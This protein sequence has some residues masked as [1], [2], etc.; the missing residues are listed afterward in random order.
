MWLNANDGE[1]VN[2][3]S[4]FKLFNFSFTNFTL[5]NDF[6]YGIYNLDDQKILHKS[7]WSRIYQGRLQMRRIYLSTDL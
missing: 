2:G 6:S 4:G 7:Y 5:N 1:K 3:F